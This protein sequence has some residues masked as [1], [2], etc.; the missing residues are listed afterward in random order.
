MSARRALRLFYAFIA[1]R[2]LRLTGA[3]WILYLLALGWPLWQVGI[4]E[5]A[6]HVVSFLTAV[7]TGYF[8]DRLGRR[9]S[10][11]VGLM[12]GALSPPLEYLLAPHGVALGSLAVGFSAL[13][14]SFIGGADQALLHDLSRRLPEAGG[15]PRLFGRMEAIALLASAVA[16]PLGGLLATRAGWLWPFLGQAVCTAL[17]ILPAWALPREV[18]GQAVEEPRG[19][20]S[21]RSPLRGALRA[22]RSSPGLTAAILFGAVLGIVATSNHLYAQSTLVLKGESVLLATAVIGLGSLLA[23]LA[24]AFAH[25]LKGGPRPSALALALLV[26]AVGP[27]RGLLGPLAY[28]GADAASGAADVLYY[29]A[30]NAQAP[31]AL[32]ATIASAPDAA[33]SLGMIALFPLEGWAMGRY[34]L[35]PAYAWLGAGLA[36][37][38]LLWPPWRGSGPARTAGGTVRRANP[39]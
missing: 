10:L 11:L 23:A 16:A 22:V 35:V 31:E 33:F 17:A 9:R 14:W 32:R 39:Q 25:R 20:R 21:E 4:A 29:A 36:V 28:V 19:G 18:S 15:F 38:A 34:G 13:S 7:P 2:W 27:A 5:A 6:F 8:A 24:S 30:L 12:I 37:A 1:L 3:V 26:A